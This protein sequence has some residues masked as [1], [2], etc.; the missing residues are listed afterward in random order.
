MG[1]NP[2]NFQARVSVTGSLANC[3]APFSEC[4]SQTEAQTPPQKPRARPQHWHPCCERFAEVN[5]VQLSA[6]MLGATGRLGGFSHRQLATC[7]NGHHHVCGFQQSDSG[8]NRGR[9]LQDN[10][11]ALAA[12]WFPTETLGNPC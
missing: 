5:V 4:N 3:L 9:F 11:W 8:I 6:L 10:S 7:L 12:M 1:I 2:N